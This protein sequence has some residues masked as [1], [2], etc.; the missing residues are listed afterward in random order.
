MQIEKKKFVG[1]VLS[2]QLVESFGIFFFFFFFEI[3]K[4]WTKN[5]K[6][7]KN[8][9]ITDGENATARL[10]ATAETD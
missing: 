4:N 6:K 9:T 2:S 3:Q 1:R 7:Q 8:A 5:Q 10:L